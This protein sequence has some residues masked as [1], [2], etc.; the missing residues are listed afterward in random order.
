MSGRPATGL[1]RPEPRETVLADLVRRARAR[2]DALPPAQRT[3]RLE[4]A[5]YH[6]RHRLDRHG[7]PDEH[8]RVDALA[9][10]LV[11]SDEA[12]LARAADDLL[13]GWAD[14]IHGRFS[15]RAYRFATTAIPPAL[16]ALLSGRPERLRDWNLD[17]LARVRIEGD[18]DFV[19]ELVD[20]A[21]LILAPTHVSN[22]DS[23]LIGL[24]LA[25]SGLPPF[26]YGAGLNLFSNPI[27]GWWMQRLGAYT[28]DRTKRAALYKDLLKDYSVRQLTRRHHSLFFPGGTRSR[29]G[30]VEPSVK[31]GLLGTGVLAWQEM[32]ADGRDDADVY[33]VPMTLSFALTLEANTLVEDYL[34]DA[35]RQRYIITDDEFAEPRTVAR[36]VQRLASL[37]A[38]IVCHFGAPLDVLGRPVPRDAAARRAASDRRTGYVTDRDGQL[39]ADAQRDRVYT[40]RLADAL[41]AAW[42]KG[43][44]ILSTHAAAWAAWRCLTEMLETED[45]FRIVRAPRARRR[46][47]RPQFLARLD[48]ELSRFREGAAE[49]RWRIELPATADDVLHDAVDA[50]CGYHRSRPIAPTGSHLVV[51][52]PRLCFYYAQRAAFTAPS[53]R[54]IG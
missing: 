11:R 30:A 32:L 29:S 2:L 6:E 5:L 9:K 18:V 1:Y 39:V 21:T 53:A 40:D 27:L 16:G 31:K 23:P 44:A 10:A 24:V 8:A 15:M 33:V 26:Q 49:G 54:E 48:E 19:R 13:H 17:A 28:V 36:F 41:V 46:I 51:E 22:L 47:P 43:A 52:D 42:P 14:E 7:T 37:D 20:E 34:A 3:Q 38:P 12:A 45:V 4:D 35:G 25:L 50:F